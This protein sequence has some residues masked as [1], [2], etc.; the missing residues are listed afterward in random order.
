M[1]EL[2]ISNQATNGT[3]E[4]TWLF[5]R[6]LP[7]GVLSSTKPTDK[8]V[9]PHWK[10]YNAKISPPN[11]CQLQTKT[12]RSHLPIIDATPS[13][14]RTLHTSMAQCKHL[15]NSLGQDTSIQTMD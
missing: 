3:K 12:H 10:G 8:I 15:T 14:K 1:N 9:V 2:K 7:R 11:S 5:L 4:T 13:N 6:M